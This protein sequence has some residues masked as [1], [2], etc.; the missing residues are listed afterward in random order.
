[1]RDLFTN[2]SLTIPSGHTVSGIAKNAHTVHVKSGRVWIT[3]EGVL[4]D[5]WLFA[6]DSFTLTPGALTVIEA[7]GATSKVELGTAGD[8]S[9][10][11]RLHRNMRRLAHL[12][13]RF[14]YSR[15]AG[16][17]LSGRAFGARETC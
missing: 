8:G 17:A 4:H 15:N 12:V 7:D 2:K 3:V 6:G 5:Y 9:S 11:A 13:Q 14:G 1:M 16:T 10:L